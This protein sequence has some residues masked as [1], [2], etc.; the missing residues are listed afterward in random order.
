[1]LFSTDVNRRL[2]KLGFPW[3]R[4]NL[5]CNVSTLS[6]L[7]RAMRAKWPTHSMTIEPLIHPATVASKI[8][9]R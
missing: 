9:R 8:G 6:E 1:M 2:Q 5:A 3:R 4:P 7:L